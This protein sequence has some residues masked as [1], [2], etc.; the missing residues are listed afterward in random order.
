M[1][2][3]IC[4][5]CSLTTYSAVRFGTTTDRCPRCDTSLAGAKQAKA[6]PRRWRVAD[7]RRA[8]SEREAEHGL[9]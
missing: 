8:L 6:T 5:G 1:P 3:L 9:G 2:Y 4:A 7:V